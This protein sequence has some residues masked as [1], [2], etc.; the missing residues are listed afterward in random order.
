ML[1]DSL[2][3]AN[4]GHGAAIAGIP[5]VYLVTLPIGFNARHRQGNLASVLQPFGR[6]GQ[7]RLVNHALVIAENTAGSGRHHIVGVPILF[8]RLDVIIAIVVAFDFKGF[9]KRAAILGC[10]LF[11]CKITL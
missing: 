10:H 11:K 5:K 4:P 3:K 9:F 1:A 6:I 2:A 7:A 8:R